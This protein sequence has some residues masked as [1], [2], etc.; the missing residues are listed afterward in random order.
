MRLAKISTKKERITIDRIV[1]S[2]EVDFDFTQLYDCFFLLSFHVRS[3]T[4]F[5]LLFYL[6]RNLPKDNIVRIDNKLRL[7]FVQI[8]EQVTGK[9][10]ISEAMFYNCLKDLQNAGIMKKLNK[11]SY[12]LNPYAMWRDDSQKRQNYIAIDA[13]SKQSFAF[14]PMQLIKEGKVEQKQER[15]TITPNEHITEG[16]DGFI[17]A[18]DR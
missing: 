1:D 18:L 4:S 9:K 13:G 10:G 11:G 12:F 6:M 15:T 16:A 7:E 14:N 8:S 3:S 17:D 5:Q 2:V